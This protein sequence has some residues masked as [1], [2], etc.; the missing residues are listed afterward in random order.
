MSLSKTWKADREKF[1]ELINPSFLAIDDKEDMDAI[2]ARTHLIVL[3][4]SGLYYRLASTSKDPVDFIQWDPKQPKDLM[5]ASHQPIFK[6]YKMNPHLQE[7][8]EN[9]FEDL[10]WSQE[11][12]RR[13]LHGETIPRSTTVLNRVNIF[14]E[15][16]ERHRV[17]VSSL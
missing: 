15:R 3:T 7:Y 11:Y 17:I 2:L 5:A 14:G 6:K 9:Y 16:S 4:E 13:L 12:I 1:L 10:A 8:P